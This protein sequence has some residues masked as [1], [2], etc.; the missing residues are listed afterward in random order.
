MERLLLKS[1]KDWNKYT[2]ENTLYIYKEIDPKEYPCILLT[3]E[4]QLP[5]GMWYTT[6]DFIYKEEVKN[7]LK[8][9]YLLK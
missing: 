3:W 1:E 2:S 8:I 5:I 6:Y 4:D 9:K 7:Y